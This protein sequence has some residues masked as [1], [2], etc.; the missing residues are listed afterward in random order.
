MPENSANNDILKELENNDVLAIDS[1]G[2]LTGKD[3]RAALK[4][5]NECEAGR[6]E[7]YELNHIKELQRQRAARMYGD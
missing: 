5:V 7:T 6:D 4:A 1:L 3:I 2:I